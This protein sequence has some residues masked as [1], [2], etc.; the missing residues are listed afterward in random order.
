MST[1]VDA[2][3]AAETLVAVV[4]SLCAMVEL[5]FEFLQSGKETAMDHLVHVESFSLPLAACIIVQMLL[6]PLLVGKEGCN[7]SC[8]CHTSSNLSSW[9]KHICLQQGRAPLALEILGESWV[10]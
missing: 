7:H 1:T 8:I 4:K 5:E 6:Q 10:V 2:P 9:N 3:I